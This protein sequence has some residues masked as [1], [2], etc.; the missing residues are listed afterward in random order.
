MFDFVDLF[1]GVGGFHS[2][3]AG[4]GGRAVQ[5]CEIDDRAASV[6]E[7]SWGL[8]PDKDVRV[9]AQDPASKV[10]DHA[11]L[12]GGFPCQP[13][14]KSGRQLGINEERGTLFQDVL[15]ILEVKQP[16]VVMLENVRNLSGPRQRG[17][18]EAILAGL[19]DAGYKVNDRP[20]VFSPHLLRPE[21]GGAPQ[22]RD[23]LYIMGV[24]VGV[25]R[26]KDETS[27][28]NAVL[29]QPEDG[30][31][32]ADWE[33]E[34]F[35]ARASR[36]GGDVGSY[37]LEP[38]EDRWIDVWDLFVQI[39]DSRGVRL[40]GH[41]LWEKFWYPSWPQ[42]EPP[43]ESMP[44]WKKRFVDLNLDFWMSNRAAIDL[45]RESAPVELASMPKT[46]RKL[47]WQAGHDDEHGNRVPYSMREDKLVQF[48][49]SGIRVKRANWAPALVAMNQTS[50]LA[51]RSRRLSPHEVARLQGFEPGELDF[52][53]QPDSQSYKQLGNAVNVGAVR[54]VLREFVWQ[55]R[56]DLRD[57][58]QG[59]KELFATLFPDEP[60][61]R[62]RRGAAC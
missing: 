27:F 7:R 14:S 48:R 38:W 59:G 53:D 4:L 9:L 58:D 47:E 34:G 3:L 1:S 62:Q 44:D 56:D 12:T 22:T 33:I 28:N 36:H 57:A 31:N 6:Y 40:P 55:N 41:P 8:A 45:W 2:A 30:W 17:A 18:W 15:E 25:A 26:A 43:Y 61:E 21:S 52:G 19:R 24:R 29:H 13:F 5:A 39:L 16:A 49:P 23:R 51:Q 10:P 37:K 50:I 60:A 11:V 46:K 42:D 35:V 20:L 54:H 32:P